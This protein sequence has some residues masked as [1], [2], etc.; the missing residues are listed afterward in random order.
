MTIDWWTLG[1]QAVNVTVLI[2]LMARFFW[3]PLAAIIEA[4]QTAAA[5]I[6]TEA[7]ARRAEAAAEAAKIAEARAGIAAERDAILT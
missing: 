1:L 3:R 2:W 5:T 4:R 6:L 7:E